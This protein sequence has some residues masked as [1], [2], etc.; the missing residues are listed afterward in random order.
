MVIQSRA[1][2]SNLIVKIASLCIL[3]VTANPQ[4]EVKPGLVALSLFHGRTAP[5]GPQESAAQFP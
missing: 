2:M 1:S 3:A 4:V 5:K